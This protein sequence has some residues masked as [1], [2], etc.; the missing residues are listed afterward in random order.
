MHILLCGLWDHFLAPHRLLLISSD[1]REPADSCPRER[2]EPLLPSLC[3]LTL[4]MGGDY[5]NQSFLWGS[6]QLP[7]LMSWQF[8]CSSCSNHLLL[9]GSWGLRKVVTREVP[10][11]RVVWHSGHLTHSPSTS[12]GVSLSFL[13]SRSVEIH[14][15]GRGNHILTYCFMRAALLYVRQ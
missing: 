6:L 14:A 13:G 4:S 7:P 11:G 15:K 12:D 5:G 2:W 1:Q 10:T 8:L 9:F 3:S